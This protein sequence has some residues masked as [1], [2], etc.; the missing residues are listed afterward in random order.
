[1]MPVRVDFWYN[2][3]VHKKRT[4][5]LGVVSILATLLLMLAL[6]VSY[7]PLP[8]IDV[9]LMRAVQS[10]G[11]ARTLSIMSF[12][13]VP[14]GIIPAVIISSIA[15]ITL[16]LSPLRTAL[17]PLA[18]VAPA[19]ALSVFLKDVIS[20]PRPPAALVNVH[21]FLLDPAF[22]SAHVVHYTVFFGFLAYLFLYTKLVPRPLRYPLTII[23]LAFV[24]L[25]PFS[26]VYLGVHWPTD[27]LAGYLLGGSILLVQIRVFQK[28]QVK[29]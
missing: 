3:F 21:Q 20:R 24:V 22:P 4:S 23:S 27:V 28:M 12:V 19:D 6:L 5:A 11:S 16:A 10:V 9:T 17:I 18:F 13:S 14:G 8:S 26:R 2:A 15:V 7:Y 29:A 25:I 1:M